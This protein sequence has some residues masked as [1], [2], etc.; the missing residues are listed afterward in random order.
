[1][2]DCDRLAPGRDDADAC[3]CERDDLDAPTAERFDADFPVEPHVRLFTIRRSEDEMDVNLTPRVSYVYS[4]IG[5]LN[6]TASSTPFATG[7]RHQLLSLG[8]EVSL[9]MR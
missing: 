2:R 4:S 7:W 6:Y 1:M 9:R 5:D 8:L 3:P